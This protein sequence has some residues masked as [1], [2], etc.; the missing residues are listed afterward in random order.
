MIFNPK[1]PVNQVCDDLSFEAYAMSQ[2]LNN[3]RMK[4]AQRSLWRFKKIL[5][6]PTRDRLDTEAL[7]QGRQFHTLL[8]E[9]DLFYSRYAVLDDSKKAEF[10]AEEKAR[11][12][13]ENEDRPP[14]RSLKI[15]TEFN[16]R[17]P[18]YKTWLEESTKGG[19]EIVDAD[20]FIGM[21]EMCEA[22]RDYEEV[23]EAIEGSQTEVTVF[24]CFAGGREEDRWLMQ[25][26]ARLDMLD[27]NGDSV[28]DLKTTVNAAAE[29]FANHIQ[30]YGYHKQLAFYVDVCRLA[31]LDK[32]RAGI[33]AIE[34]EWPYECA[35]HWIP[36]DWLELGRR[37]YRAD[38][39]KIAHAFQVDE[40]P[41]IG[42][43]EIMPPVWVEKMLEQI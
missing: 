18:A 20:W 3:T 10:L 34:K 35:L 14:S 8:L 37:E 28:I 19:M 25:L 24:G 29:P 2:G 27:L 42:V 9:P 5:D 31:G 41:R 26:K 15:P 17:F 4:A 43:A 6:N 21:S 30:K 33:L 12:E 38:L 1:N 32:S 23:W 11:V 39:Y 36:S 22:I 40:W 16:R 7:L 13:K